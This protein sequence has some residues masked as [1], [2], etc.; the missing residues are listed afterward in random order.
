MR[1]WS[2][3]MNAQV[4]DIRSLLQALRDIGDLARE[5][6]VDHRHF[7]DEGEGDHVTQVVSINP[8]RLPQDLS[9]PKIVT[10]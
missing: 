7:V 9:D 6:L 5:V 3:D 10:C 2:A 8:R 4:E 1:P